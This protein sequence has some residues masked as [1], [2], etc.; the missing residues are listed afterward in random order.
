[1]FGVCTSSQ[2]TLSKR[3]YTEVTSTAIYLVRTYAG[4]SHTTGTR[5]PLDIAR[6]R[7]AKGEITKD[8]FAEIKRELK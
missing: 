2:Q 4:H 8:E 5:D 1:M 6:E 3:G 7:Y